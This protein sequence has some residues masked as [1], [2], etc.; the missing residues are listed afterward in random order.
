M[1]I[2]R[3]SLDSDIY[4]FGGMSGVE[5]YCIRNGRYGG[6]EMECMDGGVFILPYDN[7]DECS[8]SKEN[9]NKLIAH[10]QEHI[11][12][13]HKVPAHVIPTIRREFLWSSWLYKI[14]CRVMLF[15]HRF[16]VERY[17]L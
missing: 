16:R 8:L 3:V 1:S 12:A 5:C 13:G 2:V 4:I 10:V 17:S 6:R 7:I 14:Y 11:D 15:Y 9:V